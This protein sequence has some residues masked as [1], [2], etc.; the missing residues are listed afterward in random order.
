VLRPT[1]RCL[2]DDLELK[3]PTLRDS[4][5]ELKHPLLDKARSQFTSDETRWRISSIDDNVFFKA[6]VG[7]WRGAVWCE[8]ATLDWLCAAGIRRDGSPEDFYESLADEGRRRKQEQNRLGAQ[9]TTDTFT[10]HLLPVEDDRLRLS[11]EAA[12]VDVDDIDE[13]VRRLTLEA[14]RTPGVE[15]RDTAGG[16]SIGI[17]VLESDTGMIYV[18]V[19]IVGPISNGGHAVILNAVP[20]VE[21][22]M[23]G[24][25]DMP[26]RDVSPGEVVWSNLIDLEALQSLPDE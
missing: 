26:D 11:L 4:L 25:D 19:R 15:Q 5:S 22:D 10:D 12:L 23:W 14:A 1:L 13:T 16:Y 7:R 17:Q 21:K 24:V 8:K 3:L 18:G 20:C 6:K 2:Q 9:L